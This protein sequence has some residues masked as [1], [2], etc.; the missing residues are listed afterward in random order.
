MYEHEWTAED[1]AVSEIVGD[2]LS[3]AFGGGPDGRS[4]SDSLHAYIKGVRGM[5][6]ET[7]DRHA[8][9]LLIAQAEAKR[10]RIAA[11]RDAAEVT[12]LLCA[13]QQPVAWSP[14]TMTWRHTEQACAAHTIHVLISLEAAHV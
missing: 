8:G 13:C 2:I 3:K 9:E 7:F 11:L 5:L 6:H 1:Q 4:L 14:A 10:A 12:C